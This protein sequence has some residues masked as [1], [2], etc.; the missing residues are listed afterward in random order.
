MLLLLL[1]LLYQVFLDELFKDNLISFEDE[2]FKMFSYLEKIDY[3][4]LM[5]D[6]FDVLKKEIHNKFHKDE[7]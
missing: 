1:R 4:D 7:A 3:S 2:Y 6:T 5:I